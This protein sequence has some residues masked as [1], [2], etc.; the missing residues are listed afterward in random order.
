[1]AHGANSNATAA[2]CPLYLHKASGHWCKTIKGKR[3][4]FGKDKAEALKRWYRECD[5][6]KAGVS[7]VEEE[8]NGGDRC[9]RVQLSADE[10]ADRKLEAG[11]LSVHQFR[12]LEDT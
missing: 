2:D 1:M 10:E 3:H 6:L 8:R 5:D 11:D 7:A 12:D 9:R 4:Y